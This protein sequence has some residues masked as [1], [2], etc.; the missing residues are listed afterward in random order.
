MQ[1]ITHTKVLHEHLGELRKAGK[2][3]GLVPTMGAL[4]LGHLS[5]VE[6]AKKYCEVVIVSIFVN[7]T[8]FNN[9]EDLAKYPRMPEND[10][11]LLRN[12]GCDLVFL[13]ETEEVYPQATLLK[14]DFG[15][16]ETIMEGAFRPGHFNGVGIV[17]SKLFNI[18]NPDHAFFGQKDLQQFAII[19][20]LC[21]DLSFQITLHRC[22]IVREDD[23]LAMSSRNLRLSASEREQSLLLYKALLLA[24]E[25]LKTNVWH[26]A[27]QEAL[28]LL[29]KSSIIQ[30]E[31][32]ELVDAE[33][34][35]SITELGS[36]QSAICIAAYVGQ[37][38]LLDNIIL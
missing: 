35:I 27:K 26:N 29:S 32:L 6:E 12:Q 8:Q 21:N 20:Q 13:P 10:L 34:L 11:A 19:N 9:P 17:V 24:Q 2:K 30:V 31:Y 16:L 23:G 38:R 3:I 36:K 15:Y 14:F 4:H 5:L 1:V 22:K 25:S 7:P 18:V 33:S 28:A 37:I